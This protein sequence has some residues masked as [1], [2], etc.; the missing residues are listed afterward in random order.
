[1]RGFDYMADKPV[2]YS[3][4][5]WSEIARTVCGSGGFI[6]EDRQLGETFIYRKGPGIVAEIYRY[7]PNLLPANLRRV[8]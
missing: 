2:N 6:R 1:M 5:H 8:K 4:R 3:L 7:S